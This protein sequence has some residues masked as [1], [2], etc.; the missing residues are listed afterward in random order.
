MFKTEAGALRHATRSFIRQQ[1]S[2]AVASRFAR[3]CPLDIQ[4]EAFARLYGQPSTPEYQAEVKR[5][6]NALITFEQTMD[7]PLTMNATEEEILEDAL[8]RIATAKDA[9]MIDSTQARSMSNDIKRR[10]RRRRVN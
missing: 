10:L 5:Q 4:R 1:A 2:A 8:L 7:A 6:V 9:G 3:E